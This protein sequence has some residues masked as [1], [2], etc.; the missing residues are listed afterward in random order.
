[1][2]E[3]VKGGLSWQTILL[4]VLAVAT[5]VVALYLRA[6]M[7]KFEGFFEPDGFFYY[8]AVRA[9]L[10][11]HL[12][13]PQTLPLSGFP[14]HN[15]LGEAPGILYITII[16]Y[17]ILQYFG[18]SY[19]T[20]MRV[21]PILFGLLGVLGTYLISLKW[22]KNRWLA[23]LAAFFIAVS[24]GNLGRTSAI[25]YRGDS[26]I[27]VF[28]LFSLLFL[29]K[30]FEEEEFRRQA[31][32]A[33][34]SGFI[35]GLGPAVWNGSPYIIAT[36][37]L[38]ILAIGIYGFVAGNARVLKSNLVV[39]VLGLLF[40][41]VV[42]KVLDAIG[43][44][45]SALPLAG[46]DFFYFYI[47]VMA[48]AAAAYYLVSSKKRMALIESMRGRVLL[49][50]V[51]LIAVG[52]ACMLLLG[53]IA[54]YF[55]G[56]FGI[57]ASVGQTTQELQ[58]TSFAFIL[59]S[60]NIQ[61]FLAVF[62]IIAGFAA[63]WYSLRRGSHHERQAE[64]VAAVAFLAII[65]YFIITGYMQSREI[66]FN[67]ILSMPMALLAAFGVYGMWST[68]TRL[69]EE[70]RARLAVISCSLF[71]PLLLLVYIWSYLTGTSLS[72]VVSMAV[73]AALGVIAVVLGWIALRLISA[74]R[75]GAL[76]RLVAIVAM[77][78]VAL[79]MMVTLFI[80]WQAFH[81]YYTA[82]MVGRISGAAI[83]AFLIIWQ[84]YAALAKKGI[85]LKNSF[86]IFLVLMLT[87]A[88]MQG[89]LISITSAQADGIN[90]A[91]LTALSWVRNNTPT[92][93]TFLAVWTDGSVIEGWGNRTS[94]MDS[95]GGEN[96]TKIVPFHR[97]LLNSSPDV[98]YLYS[99]DKPDYI[100]SRG[101]WYSELAGI[102]IEAEV[103]DVE[104]YGESEL[105]ILH[106]TRNGTNS[107][108][109]F[110]SDTAPYYRAELLINSSESTSRFAAF[111][112]LEN[113][114]ELQAIRYVMFYNTSSAGYNIAVSNLT[115]ALN[116]TLIVDYS[117]TNITDGVLMGSSLFNSNLFKLTFLCNYNQCPYDLGG[118]VTLTTMY[119]NNDTRIFKVN[120]PNSSS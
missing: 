88:L 74:Q 14:N 37:L 64:V 104:Q 120:Y 107:Y 22:R 108:Y 4:I 101:Y 27:N 114:T 112:G 30:S 73:A 17:L 93:A 100:L 102:A 105:P 119:M 23:L 21:I 28:I 72:A 110:D 6:V 25:I 115:S 92:N 58:A 70:G 9:T 38:T 29:V 71:A 80:P 46:L 33:L 65:S 34:L 85:D 109:F 47:P 57:S 77:D 97:W 11:N 51:A 52:V 75:R 117:G 60:F 55:N 5:V 86:L 89:Y 45:H 87:Y 111:V 50:C 42:E 2:D 94:L 26:F 24:V 68:F 95:V 53:Q 18:I 13:V 90:P 54:S 61:F 10:A 91:F 103:P 31:A 67:S 40:A 39:G 35:L 20:V 8:A 59:N 32:F 98:D 41:Y 63:I 1:M 16:P 66:R 36:Y 56:V 19:Y 69:D 84:V 15:P 12:V 81:A 116:Y 78:I 7:L 83:F 48:S 118:N 113:S 49:V 82:V 106:L 96:I 43:V 44:A 79:W 3:R 99:A 76:V 62:G